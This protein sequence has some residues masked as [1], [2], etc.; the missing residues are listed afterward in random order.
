MAERVDASGAAY[1]GSQ[2]LTQLYVNART[3]ELD[4][5]IR[6]EFPELADATLDWRSPRADKNF[7]EHWDAAFL[8]CLDLDAHVDALKT[9]WPSG[10][11]HW[12]AL[13]IASL[14][15]SDAPGVLLVEGKSYPGEM[16]EGSP[17]T[18]PPGSDSRVRIEKAL[19]WTQ[20]RLALP[21]NT[22]TWTGPLYQNANR[23]AHLCWLQSRGVRTWLVHL[24]FTGAPR[25]PTTEKDWHDALQKAD[26][27]LGLTGV[28]V[29]SAGHVL[30]P[31][32]PREELVATASAS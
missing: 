14:P 22:A 25:A 17:A 28:A 30:L 16:L 23:L 10:G 12:D 24:L 13:A 26:E 21:L 19:A 9:F 11:P 5:G 3:P 18:S 20:G 6:A 31:A 15:G 27:A 7:A 29:P 4:A 2:M 8:K 32:R 1:A